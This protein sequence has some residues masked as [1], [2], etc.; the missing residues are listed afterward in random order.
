MIVMVSVVAAVVSAVNMAGWV[1][2]SI[3][4]SR[5]PGDGDCDNSTVCAVTAA[6]ASGADLPQ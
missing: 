2:G 4:S 1:P 6:V 3:K 5:P